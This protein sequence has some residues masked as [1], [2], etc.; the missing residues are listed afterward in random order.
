MTDTD[1][2][3]IR[4]WASWSYDC[5]ASWLTV[6]V[7]SV[8]N[9]K[10]QWLTREHRKLLTD[11]ELFNGDEANSI[12]RKND[13]D[14]LY[15]YLSLCFEKNEDILN[16]FL[17]N[18]RCTKIA[19]NFIQAIDFFANDHVIKQ[20][21]GIKSDEQKFAILGSL[22]QARSFFQNKMKTAGIGHI[23]D[24]KDGVLTIRTNI[25]EDVKGLAATISVYGIPN[26]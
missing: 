4:E 9:F 23:Q 5:E 14:E 1:K 7:Q 16:K 24:C 22:S 12:M 18:N 11:A 6:T 15:S 26:D 2:E 20:V 25:V 19:T 21:I 8:K 13:L 10:K 17:N 3:L